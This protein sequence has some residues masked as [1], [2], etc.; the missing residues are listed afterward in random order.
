LAP[1]RQ[2]C[3]GLRLAEAPGKLVVVDGTPS[4]MSLE[5]PFVRLGLVVIQMTGTIKL[6]EGDLAI[7]EYNARP[8]VAV[9][10]AWLLI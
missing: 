4:A 10:I 3:H 2:V 1:F 6:K 7:F 8:S 5:A 9:F